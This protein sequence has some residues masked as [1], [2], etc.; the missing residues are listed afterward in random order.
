MANENRSKKELENKI[1]SEQTMR[2]I[3]NDSLICKNCLLRM[4]DTV[5]FGNTS[6]CEQFPAKPVEVLIGGGCEFFI[7]E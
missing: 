2:R 5:I 3:T 1:K 4:N 7:K 6:R